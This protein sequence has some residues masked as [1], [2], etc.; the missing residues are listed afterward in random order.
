MKSSKIAPHRAVR[1]PNKAVK[2]FPALLALM[3]AALTRD[4]LSSF[5][6]A[7]APTG[8]LINHSVVY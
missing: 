5:K 3:R 7:W 6:R 2:L 8:H 1:V 4:C